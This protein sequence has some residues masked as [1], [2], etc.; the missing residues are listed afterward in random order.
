MLGRPP[1]RRQYLADGGIAT[2]PTAS[3]DA[4]VETSGAAGNEAAEGR[5]VHCV[6]RSVRSAKR[7]VTLKY[8][9]SESGRG[10]WEL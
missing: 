3:S 8:R 9:T 2:R 10:S 6:S 1:G 5:Q 4:A 7:T